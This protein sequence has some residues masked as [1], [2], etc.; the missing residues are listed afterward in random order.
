VEQDDGGMG[1]CSGSDVD[2]GIELSAMAGEL[3]GLDCRG[4]RLDG[5]RVFSNGR[6]NLCMDGQGR[7]EQG[8]EGEQ[9]AGG[10]DRDCS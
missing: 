2:E 3:V 4:I 8:G 10:H 9:L 5:R 7:G 6:R 1:T